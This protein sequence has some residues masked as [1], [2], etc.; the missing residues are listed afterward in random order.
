M[1]DHKKDHKD[2]PKHKPTQA[3]SASKMYNTKHNFTTAALSISEEPNKRSSPKLGHITQKHL[4][5]KD[6]AHF[7]QLLTDTFGKSL[8]DKIK[9]TV[10]SRLAFSLTRITTNVAKATVNEQKQP[11][12]SGVA[13]PQKDND[14]TSSPVRDTGSMGLLEEP[15]ADK[16]PSEPQKFDLNKLKV[17]QKRLILKELQSKR[18]KEIRFLRNISTADQLAHPLAADKTTQ[19]TARSSKQGQTHREYLLKPDY[20]RHPAETSKGESGRFFHQAEKVP[21]S[22]R[23]SKQAFQFSSFSNR[24]KLELTKGE[25]TSYGEGVM[26]QTPKHSEFRISSHQKPTTEPSWVLRDNVHISHQLKQASKKSRVSGF[27]SS[28]SREPSAFGANNSQSTGIMGGTSASRLAGHNNLRSSQTPYQQS[29]YRTFAQYAQ[30]GG[31]H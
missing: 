4:L 12:T 16:A 28:T 11:E 10:R 3:A 24:R 14:S 23:T 9:S 25:E 29:V 15:T 18:Q 19:S 26:L 7:L 20:I 5:L 30:V 8:Q 21:T 27:A 6:G 22:V 17:T 2:V 31:L 13:S 1:T